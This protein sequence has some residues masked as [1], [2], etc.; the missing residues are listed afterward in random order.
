MGKIRSIKINEKYVELYENKA[1]HTTYQYLWNSA[2]AVL[3]GRFRAL[4][5]Y[6]RKDKKI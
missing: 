3:T 5:A 1:F 6:T 2:R 4:N